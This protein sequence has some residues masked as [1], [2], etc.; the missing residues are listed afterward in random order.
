MNIIV[1]GNGAIG[2]ERIKAIKAIGDKV[3]AVIDKDDNLSDK[4]LDQA[5]WVFIC[6]PHQVTVEWVNRIRAYSDVNILVEKP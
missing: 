5:D 1:I 3:I 4:T 6:T 2:K